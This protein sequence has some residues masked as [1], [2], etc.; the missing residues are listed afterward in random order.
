M[1]TT[2]IK[3][4]LNGCS[5][6]RLCDLLEKTTTDKKRTQELIMVRGWIM[7]EME[8]KNP[9]GFENWLMSD[10]NYDRDARK[11]LI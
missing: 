1:T 3:K 9:K 7:D 6:E 5:I 4:M 10:D 2:Q 11:Y 8:A